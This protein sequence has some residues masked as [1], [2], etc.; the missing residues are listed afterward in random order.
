MK[1]VLV[2]Y[3]SQTGQLRSVLDSVTST[4]GKD[5]HVDFAEIK[6]QNPYPFPWKSYDVFFDAMPESVL[7]I[8][9][10]IIP[11]PQ[12]ID[13][14]YDLVIIGFQPWFLSPSI[15]I[16]SFLQSEWAKVLEK[17]KVV[18]VIGSRNMWLRALQKVKGYLHELGAMHV[19]NIVLEDRNKNIPSTITIVKWMIS[20]DKGPSKK[21]PEAGIIRSD[22]DNASRFGK[23][24]DDWMKTDGNP[25]TLH[26]KLI[27]AGAVTLKPELMILESRGARLF[28]KWAANARKLGLPGDP[29]RLKVLRKFKKVLFVTI[30]ILSPISGSMAK[31][32][33]AMNKRK[34]KE[35]WQYYSSIDFIPDFI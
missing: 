24:I 27:E 32:K 2:L 29:A 18:T 3:F 9:Q 20:G 16:T 14:S 4:L 5:V 10:P 21:Y 22:I 33:A 6:L 34:T 11:M 28:P 30:F 25:K 7:G 35:D 31:L 1:R 12:I 15:P 26:P 17:K 8:A 23:I 13:K 19:G